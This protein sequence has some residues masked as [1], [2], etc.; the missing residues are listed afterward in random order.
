[1]LMNVKPSRWPDVPASVRKVNDRPNLIFYLM[2][3]RDYVAEA[4]KL[5]VSWTAQ[6]EIKF[7]QRLGRWA[8][9][10]RSE[11]FQERRKMLLK[12]ILKR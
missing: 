7:L 2:T 9:R 3:T 11:N 6:D 10:D 4:A 1:M 8:R 12:D 5:K